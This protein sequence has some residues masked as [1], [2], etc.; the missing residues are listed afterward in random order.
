MSVIVR[1][2]EMPTNCWD[3]PLCR[4]IRTHNVAIDLIC[5]VKRHSVKVH[6]SERA[7]DCP[8]FECHDWREV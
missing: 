7:E 1:D 8:L 5:E 3:C 6:Y 2:I 4:E